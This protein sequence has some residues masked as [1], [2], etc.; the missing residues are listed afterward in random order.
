VSLMS[1]FFISMGLMF[2]YFCLKSRII[3]S[4]VNAQKSKHD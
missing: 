4:D 3:V 2:M 1:I